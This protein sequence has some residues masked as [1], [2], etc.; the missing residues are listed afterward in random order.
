MVVDIIVDYLL[1]VFKKRWVL[2][3]FKKKMG[4]VCFH[5]FMHGT[6][7]VDNQPIREFTK[8]KIKILFQYAFNKRYYSHD[9]SYV[10]H[11]LR[12]QDLLWRAI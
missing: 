5:V 7:V 8:I 6:G 3:V 2:Y 1:Y 9:N 11:L 12:T 4:F 10:L